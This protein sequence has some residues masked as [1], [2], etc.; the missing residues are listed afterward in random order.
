MAGGRGFGDWSFADVV[1]RA[2]VRVGQLRDG[3]RFPVE[4]LA[5]LRVRGQRAWQNLDGDDPVEPRVAGA[6]DLAHPAGTKRSQ[7]LVGT[8]LRSS[9][10]A[11][12]VTACEVQEP[13]CP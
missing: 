5:E 12:L 7:D 3:A 9:R 6:I 4:P 11:H 8:E 10:E 2:D 1:Q 13:A